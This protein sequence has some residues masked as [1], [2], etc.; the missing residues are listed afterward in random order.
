MKVID[1]KELNPNE[2][3]DLYS[4]G[5]DHLRAR[6]VGWNGKEYITEVKMTNFTLDKKIQLV[7]YCEITDAIEVHYYGNKKDPF[8]RGETFTL[9]NCKLDCVRVILLDYDDDEKIRPCSSN[10][11]LI[12][13]DTK[14]GNVIIGNP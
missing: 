11:T 1:V 3:Y 13:P 10:D 8:V 12:H 9:T 7:N 14:K 4:N 6:F 2:T 5:S